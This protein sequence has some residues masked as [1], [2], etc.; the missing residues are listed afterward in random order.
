MKFLYLFIIC[1]SLGYTLEQYELHQ[2]KDR[3]SKIEEDIFFGPFAPGYYIGSRSSSLYSTQ[4]TV[5]WSG[6]GQFEF[7]NY[8]RHEY[9][10]D[11]EIKVDVWSH[12]GRNFM[13]QLI[14]DLKYGYLINNSMIYNPVKKN[15]AYDI[16]I[17]TLKDNNKP[18]SLMFHFESEKDAD[19]SLKPLK[20]GKKGSKS[21]IFLF[22]SKDFGNNKQI[23]FEIE[24]EKK[25]NKEL[26]FSMLNQNFDKPKLKKLPNIE[27]IQYFCD[28]DDDQ[29]FN[30]VTKNVRENLIKQSKLLSLNMSMA[31]KYPVLL[32]NNDKGRRCHLQILIDGNT[33]IT[34]Y[35]HDNNAK[36]KWDV[37]ESI[38]RAI[39]EVE[40]KLD[41]FK[42]SK[43]S[44]DV[45][46]FAKS[47]I[48]SQ[49]SH[50]GWFS[51]DLKYTNLDGKE[52]YLPNQKLF[53]S[54]PSRVLFPRGFVWDEAFQSLLYSRFDMELAKYVLANWLAL[55]DVKTGWIAR[56]Q[57]LGD[58]GRRRVPPQFVMQ[59][60]DYSNPPAFFL[61][62]ARLLDISSDDSEYWNK[63]IEPLVLHAR[64][65]ERYIRSTTPLKVKWTGREQ[66][67]TL[68]SGLDD[69]P[70]G[71]TPVND[72][73]HVDLLSWMFHVKKTLNRLESVVHKPIGNSNDWFNRISVESFKNSV[74]NV[75]FNSETNVFNDF[76]KNSTQPGILVNHIGYISYFP[77]R[78][79]TW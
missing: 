38:K 60:M 24:R 39:L 77:W 49:L 59:F 37:Q 65:F 32:S 45:Y 5:S 8:F 55:L 47:A 16:D 35:S 29:L 44:S 52:D 34:M 78:C 63:M 42:I 25:M 15:F 4:V 71:W 27:K 73:A 2:F 43:V 62:V 9:K 19:F 72:E 69:Y 75:H 22:E 10:H 30:S 13:G 20:G 18:L 79:L 41:N 64:Y 1:F 54:C 57:I 28:D 61:T 46:M 3:F 74:F 67:H 68:T 58:S 33:H 21:N 26:F 14:E 51:G 36:E 40:N 50:F 23:I 12:N 70:R 17:K 7:R 6:I 48:F 76:W 53:A 66:D 31:A 11:N 56:E